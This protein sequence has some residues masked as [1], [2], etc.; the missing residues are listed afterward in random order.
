MLGGGY[1]AEIREEIAKIPDADRLA[2]Y[3]FYPAAIGEFER[4]HG[5]RGD[6]REHFRAALSLARNSMEQRYFA[7][8]E[9]ESSGE[10]TPLGS[11]TMADL[12]EAN[13]PDGGG[14]R[15]A[16]EQCRRPP[17]GRAPEE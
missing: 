1:G 2:K 4:R 10:D 15:H 6:A 11:Q 14:N 13:C 12:R 8:R 7:R 17:V 9:R 16:K 3:P 5:R